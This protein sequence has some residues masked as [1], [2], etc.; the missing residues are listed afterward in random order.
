MTTPLIPQEIFLLERY[1]SLAYLEALRDTWSEMVEH[2]D[3]CLERFMLDLPADYRS[4]PLAEQPDAVWGE[5]VL[6]NFRDTLDSLNRACALLR[7]GDLAGLSSCN[8]PLSDYK[9]QTEF[10]SGWMSRDD[11]NR[12]GALL[13]AAV[14]MAANIQATEG[15]YWDPGD[16]T[17]GYDTVSRGPLDPP[18]AWPAYRLSDKIKVATD[19]PLPVSGIYLPDVANSCAQ[20]LHERYSVAPPARVVRYS[21]QTA[22]ASDNSSEIASEDQPCVWTL[23]VRTLEAIP[24]AQ[25][26]VAE[27]PT[28]RVIAGQACPRS[29]VW[30]TPARIGSRR[31]FE[32]GETMPSLNSDFGITIWQWHP[33]Q[34]I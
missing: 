21:G 31:H 13:N 22:A 25:P 6:P 18:S 2:L 27:P 11:E 9:G 15:A 23:V 7:S 3:S 4:R 12:Y 32:Q 33:D 26:T 19:T 20:F 1:A 30:F 24:A 29:G 14:L 17:S 34:S 10:W 28:E 16:L 5:L 8:G